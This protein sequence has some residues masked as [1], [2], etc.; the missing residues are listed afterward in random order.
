ML[1]L[2]NQLGGFAADSMPSRGGTA[3]YPKPVPGKEEKKKLPPSSSAL[4]AVTG[5]FCRFCQQ[6]G[7]GT[8]K[9]LSGGVTSSPIRNLS[10]NP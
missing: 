5:S 4:E 3:A 1:A 6:P 7:R 9:F 10:G 2:V 8:A